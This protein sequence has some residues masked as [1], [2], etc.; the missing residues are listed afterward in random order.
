MSLVYFQCCGRKRKQAVEEPAPQAD[1]QA[2]T[3]AINLEDVRDTPRRRS[4]DIEVSDIKGSDIDDTALAPAN[5]FL[6][7]NFR[8]PTYRPKNEVP[9][10]FSPANWVLLTISDVLSTMRKDSHLAR[11]VLF[12]TVRLRRSLFSVGPVKLSQDAR[13]VDMQ[14]IEL[15][16]VLGQGDELIQG[17]WGEESKE[18]QDRVLKGEPF[19]KALRTNYISF[20]PL[21]SSCLC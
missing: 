3:Q 8:L 4:T 1:P 10:F 15:D 13:A 5:G 20:Y 14:L 21:I 11:C 12:E 18:K 19:Q 16:K 17:D 2:T 6:A 9:Q 7:G